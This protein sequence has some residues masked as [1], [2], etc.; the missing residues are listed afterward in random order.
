MNIIDRQI[1]AQ[2]E[3]RINFRVF[4]TSEKDYKPSDEIDDTFNAGFS[5]AIY[6]Q[7]DENNKAVYFVEFDCASPRK[8][9]EESYLW[10]KDQFTGEQKYCTDKEVI[11]T[12]MTPKSF[13]SAI[14]N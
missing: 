4:F 13:F 3:S 5:G 6:K 1:E 11:R 2:I 9:C 10:V 14:D 7:H 8:I 12:A